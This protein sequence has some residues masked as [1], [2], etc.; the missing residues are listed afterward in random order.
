MFLVI[1]RKKDRELRERY[2]EE[3]KETDNGAS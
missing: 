2:S 3:E 1:K